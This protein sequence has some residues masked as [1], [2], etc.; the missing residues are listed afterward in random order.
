LKRRVVLGVIPVASLAIFIVL[1]AA[2]NLFSGG[3]SNPPSLLLSLNLI[4]ITG[5]NVGVGLLSARSYLRNGSSNIL[6]L[7]CGLLISGLAALFAGWASTFSTNANVT[8]FNIG[9]L[10][11]GGVQLLAGMLAI[12]GSQISDIGEKKP[13]Y[14]SI[15]GRCFRS[16][17]LALAVDGLLPEFLR[18]LVNID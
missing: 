6:T 9:I 11:A 12:G 18:L 4:F 16:F 3:I 10:F 15:F 14:Y 2:F 17:D 1:V 7:S 13:A 8:I 5:T